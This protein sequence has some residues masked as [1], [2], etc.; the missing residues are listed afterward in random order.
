MIAAAARLNA[1]ARLSGRVALLGLVAFATMP[2]CGGSEAE[3]F[4][5]GT[6]FSSG[7]TPGTP[8]HRS[9]TWYI[10]WSF[11]SGSFRQSGY[12][13]LQSEGR[14]RVVRAEAAAITLTLYN[15]KGNFSETDRTIEIAIDKAGGTISVNKGPE[16]RRKAAR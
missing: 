2:S 6:W 16:L 9:V 13:P 8:Q 14:Y 4:I 7:T 3:R 5:Q 1:A 15:Q 12:P 11:E 10:E